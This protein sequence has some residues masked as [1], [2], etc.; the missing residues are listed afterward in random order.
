M[1]G[2]DLVNQIKRPKNVVNEKQNERMIVIPTDHQGID[3]QDK[4]KNA[5]VSL[6]HDNE[7]DTPW[8][9]SNSDMRTK[10]AKTVLSRGCRAINCRWNKR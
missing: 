4:I 2:Q 3:S 9:F 8:A 6:V 7:L 10:L 1:T 5:T